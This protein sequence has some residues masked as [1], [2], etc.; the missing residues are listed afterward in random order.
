MQ[1]IDLSQVRDLA[2]SIIGGGL[3]NTVPTSRANMYPDGP[4]VLYVVATNT[5][6]GAVTLLARLNWKEAQA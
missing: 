5:T 2:N 1:Q 6:G 4:D 3:N